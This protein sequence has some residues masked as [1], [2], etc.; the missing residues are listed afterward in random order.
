MSP[1]RTPAVEE[2]TKIVDEHV[3]ILVKHK[4]RMSPDIK[5]GIG[6]FAWVIMFSTMFVAC[7]K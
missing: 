5:F 3:P 6:V 1:Y 2:E 7:L 4:R